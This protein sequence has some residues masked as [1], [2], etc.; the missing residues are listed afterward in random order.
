MLDVDFE[1]SSGVEFGFF[2]VF[3]LGPKWNVSDK[4]LRV[5][6]K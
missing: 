6:T 2:S 3:F 1:W 4:R 5:E